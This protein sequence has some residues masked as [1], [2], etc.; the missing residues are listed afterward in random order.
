MSSKQARLRATY[1]LE[2]PYSTPFKTSKTKSG[3]QE[4]LAARYMFKTSKT[5]SYSSPICPN[6][7]F[8]TSKT[9]SDPKPLSIS[10]DGSKQ[11]R[12]RELERPPVDAE[13]RS[14]QARLRAM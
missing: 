11:A 3:V 4:A 6:R 5:K 7:P 13:T 10:R 8:K 14:K 1:P 12:L 2:P 9:K